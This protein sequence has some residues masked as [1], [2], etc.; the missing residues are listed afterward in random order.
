MDA[1]IEKVYAFTDE[2]A[3]IAP[4][5]RVLAAVSGGADSMALLSLLHRWQQAELTLAVVH[6]HHGIRGAE[7][8]R[9]AAFV[10]QMCREWH[11]PLFQ[12]RAD[13]P[14]IA[15]REHLGLEEAG[16]LVRYSV[17]ELV[18]AVWQADRIAT[19]HTASDRA[20]T[21]LLHLLRGCGMAGLTGIPA[22][23]GRLVRP[24]LS[25]TRAEIEDYCC[26]FSVP[27][28]KD[29]TNDDIQYTRNAVRRQ[30]LPLMRQQNP[31]VEQALLRLAD[32]AAEDE[33]YL[34][35]Q[36]AERLAECRMSDGVDGRRLLAAPAA[37]GYRMLQQALLEYGCRSMER[38]H[39]EECRRMLER[40][41]GA[42][43]LPGG[44][45]LTAAAGVLRIEP[46]ATDSAP[47]PES[48]ALTT[49][50]YAGVW[51]GRRF[52][53]RPVNT[54]DTEMA[55]NVHRMFFKS[56]VD[57][58]RIQSDLSV[59]VRLPGD[60]LY[61][62]GRGVGKSVRRLMQE[63]RLPAQQRERFPLLCDSAGI[64]LL[65]GIT[66][67]DRVRLTDASRH[68]LVWEWL[69]EPSYCCLP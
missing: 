69:D 66:C 61:P 34:A 36:A 51:C 4:H 59:R 47:L 64:V 18:A 58:D 67:A 31:A 38:R 8:D 32:S 62:A 43:C 52:C 55:R 24:L 30:L 57:Y 50:P 37:I 53:V 12:V 14:A 33:Q 35:Q 42:V 56:A 26:R 6:V 7:A 2:N 65:P 41:S 48:L 9:D 11:I 16:R 40:G 17:F 45:R 3:L 25:C 22:Q 13:V 20:E 54:E 21:V 49:L 1:I 27:Y 23:R 63:I 19:A 44:W 28:V 39:F 10:T 60:R 46:T 5:E 68:F 29:S 15:A